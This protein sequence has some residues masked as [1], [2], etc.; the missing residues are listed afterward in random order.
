MS[1][2]AA[3]QDRISPDNTATGLLESPMDALR[4]DGHLDHPAEVA[5]MLHTLMPSKA[6]VL[7]VGCGTGALT[8]IANH[9]RGN[10][11]VCVE[12]DPQRAEMARSRGLQV[13]TGFLTEDLIEQLGQFDVVMASDVLEHTANPADFLSLLKSAVK[14]GG[15]ILISVPNVAHWSVRAK[16][17]AGQFDYEQF[18]IMDATHLRWFTEK[19]IVNLFKQC[20]LDPVA[21]KQ[22]AG[23]DLPI[24]WR[25]VLRRVPARLK[26]PVIRGA[27]RLWPK[28]FGVQH[29]VLAVAA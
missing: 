26:A 28:L 25:G 22:S 18:G 12:P 15:H 17:L 8:L 27:V 16:L 29:V 21:V 14:P 11:V 24:Y 5:G 6:R 7:D 23:S 4:Y 20:E 10:D 2:A 9:G 3:A 19:T 13:H 1:T